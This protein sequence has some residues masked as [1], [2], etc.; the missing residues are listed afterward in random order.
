MLENL[1]CFEIWKHKKWQE[2]LQAKLLLKDSEVIRLRR[3]VE[4]Y[5]KNVGLGEEAKKKAPCR[6]P[7][8]LLNREWTPSFLSKSCRLTSKSV[9]RLH[10]GANWLDEGFRLGTR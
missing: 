1:M 8:P 5:R 3:E 10:N 4:E 2:E 6:E 9:H 7:F